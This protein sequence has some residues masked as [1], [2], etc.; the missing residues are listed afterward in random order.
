[1]IDILVLQSSGGPMPGKF[2]TASIELAVVHVCFLLHP[3][4]HLSQKYAKGHEIRMT[5]R[6]T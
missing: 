1:M 2:I 5:R 3:T 6:C 4:E